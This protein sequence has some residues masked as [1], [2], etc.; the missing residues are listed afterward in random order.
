[1]AN[2]E[3][4]PT[5]VPKR[6]Q[7]KR[8][9]EIFLIFSISFLFV[10]LT[11][12]EIRLYS[13]SQQLPFVHSIF[14]FGLVNFNIILLLL[15]LFLIFRNLVKVFVES[16]SGVFGSSLKAKLIAA[17]VAFSF[18]PTVLI[19]VISVFYIN[20]SFDKWFS[21][22]MVGVLK[23]S[24]EVQNAYYFS[25]KKRNYHFAEA[26]A[27]SLHQLLAS[28][29]TSRALQSRLQDLR[30]RFALDALEYYPKLLGE[31]VS[32][33]SE[34]ESL[35]SLPP[36][37][38]EFLQKGIVS[39]VEASTIHQF[40]DG[41]LIRVV[42]PVR[43]GKNLGAVVVSTFIPL[44]LVSRMND[45]TEAYQEFRDINPLEYPLKSIYL[46]VLALMT[47]VI[48]LAATWFG[49]YLARQLSIPL[50]QLGLATRRVVQGDYTPLST[51]TGSEEISTLIESFNRMTLDLAS[52]TNNLRETLDYLEVVL[53]NISTGVISVDRNNRIT[54][55]NRLAARIL[56]I[57]P[58][59]YLGQSVRDLL[60]LEYFRIFAEMIRSIQMNQADSV[61]K[62]TQIQV[63]GQDIP[64]AMSLSI[65]RNAEG[66]EMGKVLVFDDLTPILNAQRAA[67]WTEVA[68][69]IAHE[70]KNPLTPI[71]L[72]A[73][74]ILR[75]FSGQIQDPVFR[76]SVEMIIKQ[77]TEIKNL[78]NEFSHFSRLPETHPVLG[79]IEDCAEEALKVFRSSH[80]QAVL[81]TEW[82]EKTPM[83][84]FDPD[85]MRRALI[86]LIDNG[87]SATLPGEKP[88]IVLETKYEEKLQVLKLAVIDYGRGIP[89]GD[90]PRVLEPYFSTKEGGTGLG[91]PIV[92]RIV[93]DHNGVLRVLANEPRGTKMVIEL[94]LGSVRK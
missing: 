83:F 67:A 52:S 50:V 46:I 66:V 44:S 29:S 6:E 13:T 16:Q 54:T 3:Q 53:R 38:L 39:Q 30:S 61:Q 2:P 79:R 86:N 76:E 72:A 84:K 34:E 37:S 28:P 32:A 74:R 42:V 70:I 58:E 93:E 10:F 78:V 25:A 23:S 1:M 85:Q 35:R 65:L 5:L 7:K 9:R 31:R 47:L 91:L 94:P 89:E 15:L 57:D 14:F 48:L 8:K 81:K 71:R 27:A 26:A 21:V 56:K 51:N 11:W 92:K 68:R 59:K 41:N 73:E 77:S 22:K 60:T 18:I 62:E 36:V 4:G 17:F 64:L 87:L 12:F 69:R 80:S 43:E 20:S 33:L 40:G 88:L 75:K 19:F 45:V 82:D 24:L 90:R 55:I 63:Q 49:I